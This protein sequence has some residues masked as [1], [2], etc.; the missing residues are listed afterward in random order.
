MSFVFLGFLFTGLAEWLTGTGPGPDG[1][2]R[3]PSCELQGDW[4]ASDS[5]EKMALRK[6]L[7]VI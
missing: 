1:T 6:S 7:N 4:P 5:G 2:I 3:A